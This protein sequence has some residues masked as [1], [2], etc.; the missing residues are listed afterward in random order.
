MYKE[1]VEWSQPEASGQQ[2]NVQLDA[3]DKWCS[4]GVR[5]GTSAA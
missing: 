4:L 3:S 5:D 2:L 1:L